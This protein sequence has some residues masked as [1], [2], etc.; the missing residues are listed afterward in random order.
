MGCARDLGML[1]LLAALWG[2]SF[3]SMRFVVQAT[4]PVVLAFIRVALVAA[5]LARYALLS[6][7]RL[8]LHGHWWNFLI[9]AFGT[10]LP[11]PVP[12]GRP[13]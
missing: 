8:A 5:G 13:R 2:A 11:P 9:L 4:G 3:L 12:A 10:R 7:Q 1:V 6:R